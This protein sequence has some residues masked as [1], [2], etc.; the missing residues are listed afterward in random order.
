MAKSYKIKT[1]TGV[2]SFADPIGLND[3]ELAEQADNGLRGQGALV[4]MMSRLRKSL[5]DLDN[6]TTR[7]S[8]ILVWLTIILVILTLTLVGTS[9][10]QIKLMSR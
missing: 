3:E 4:E 8:Q 1:P 5:V 7:Y 9:A 10:L 2:P 6:A